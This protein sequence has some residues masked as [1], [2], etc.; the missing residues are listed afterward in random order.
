MAETVVSGGVA[1][2]DAT[3]F[4]GFLELLEVHLGV[5]LPAQ[6]GRVSE[7]DGGGCRVVSLVD[8]RNDF[9]IVKWVGGASARG[10]EEV[11]E[12]FFVRAQAA[13]VRAGWRRWSAD[14]ANGDA[15]GAPAWWGALLHDTAARTQEGVAPS[16]E[17]LMCTYVA[18][19]GAE[20]AVDR[21]AGYDEMAELRDE[22]VRLRAQCRIVAS[23]RRQLAERQALLQGATASQIRPH[24]TGTNTVNDLYVATNLDGFLAW[25]ADNA[26]RL[27]VAGRAHQGAKKSIYEKPGE[28]YAALDILAGPY[29]DVKMG[30]GTWQ[31]VED[32]LQKGGFSMQKSGGETTLTSESSYTIKWEG[33][34]WLLSQHITKGGGRDERYCLRIYFAWDDESKRIV[35][36]WLPSHLPNSLT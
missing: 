21:P 28:I 12:A 18:T 23:E 11:E 10:D 29:R 25:C 26:D 15:P 31:A 3:L 34:R 24:A 8:R 7:V 4:R 20:L 13:G 6:D 35:V 17:Q 16:F 9:A 19:N 5:E 22:V 27:V 32:A 33:A 2:V 14:K 30:L 36:G 1:K